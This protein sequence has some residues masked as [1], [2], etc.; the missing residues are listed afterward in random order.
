MSYAR[1]FAAALAKLRKA[2]LVAGKD[3]FKQVEEDVKALW[4]D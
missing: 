3:E 4:I 2:D 1:C